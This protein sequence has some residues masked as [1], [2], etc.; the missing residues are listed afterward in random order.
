MIRMILLHSHFRS[1][2]SSEG[3]TKRM[4]RTART[5]K[6][7]PAVAAARSTSPPPDEGRTAAIPPS[8]PS[9]DDV[10]D[11][12]PPLL[13][14]KWSPIPAILSSAPPPSPI[15]PAEEAPK[16][17]AVF[18]PKRRPRSSSCRRTLA[19]NPWLELV[20]PSA[21]AAAATGSGSPSSVLSDSSETLSD[22]LRSSGITSDAMHSYGDETEMEMET[23][24][25]GAKRRGGRQLPEEPSKMLRSWLAA[26]MANPYP[27]R[28]EKEQLARSS[29]LRYKQV[30]FSSAR[31]FFN[32]YRKCR[33]FF[34][35]F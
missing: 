32:F 21:A 5:P 26:N 20:I 3:E 1:L 13:E 25:R 34:A 18:A 17:A 33:R 16:I 31:N 35:I 28:Q 24:S 22:Q 9:L 2:D 14:W 19:T 8:S 23:Q 11:R 12:L 30:R 7:S 29:G 27:S 6:L 4:L 15:A 10:F